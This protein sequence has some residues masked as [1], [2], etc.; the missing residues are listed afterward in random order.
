MDTTKEVKKF[1][2]STAFFMVKCIFRASPIL[3]PLLVILSIMQ[4]G[5]T[6]YGLF[7]LKDATNALV[8]LLTLDTTLKQVLFFVFLYLII[9]IVLN[10]LLSALTE[11]TERHYYKQAD[12]YFRILLLYKLG[13]LPQ[14]N[15]Y[16]SEVYNKYEFTYHYLYMFQQ[17]PWHL[18]R[19]L[20]NFSFSKILYLAI[21]FSFNPI[22]GVYCL[23]LF[24]INI[25]VSIFITNKQAD[26][27]K[28]NILPNRQKDYYNELLTTKTNI[29]E[30]KINLLENHFFAKFKNLYIQVRDSLFKIQ[31]SDTIIKQII[32]ILN[33]LFNNGLIFLL[34]YMVFKGEIDIGELTLIQLAGSSLIFAAGQ[35]QQPTKYIVQFVKYAPTMIDMLYPLTKEEIK[36]MKEKEY[37]EF[38][39]KLGNFNNIKLEN[40]SFNYPSKEDE[41][42]TNVNLK[43]NKGEIISILGYN[44]SGKTTLC[45]LIAGILDPSSGKIYFNDEDIQDLDKRE[46]YKYFGIGFQD[47]AKYS[48]SLRDNIGFGRIEERLNDEEIFQAVKK[49]NLQNI[50]EKLPNGLDTILGKEYDKEGQDLSIGQW[51]RVILARAYMGSPEI[52]ILD[53]PTASI[54]PFEEERMLDEFELALENKTAILISHRISFA[55]LADK[56]IMMKDGKIEEAGSHEELINNKGYYYKLFSSQQELYREVNKDEK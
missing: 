23:F 56:I 2:L 18:I 34:I 32:N 33:F 13:K 28:E 27:D 11:L 40:V 26:V 47:Y 45:K 1:K 38:E 41:A 3:F 9:E 24:I 54:D 21:I 8:G 43:I 16:D 17:L 22:V 35:F 6:A 55:R 19:F 15:M 30:T 29:K 42:V 12:R 50:I 52:L 7:V 36:D 46:Y 4:I 44:G 10:Q 14:I 31:K 51:Q 53:E 49:T 20:I 5:L 37:P 48:L 39:L 25:L